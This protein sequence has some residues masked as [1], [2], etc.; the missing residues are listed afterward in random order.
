[1]HELLDKADKGVYKAKNSEK[2]T[3]ESKEIRR[4]VIWVLQ[5]G[6]KASRL[7]TSSRS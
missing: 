6:W 3:T 7:P 1:M 5:A 4:E 2:Q